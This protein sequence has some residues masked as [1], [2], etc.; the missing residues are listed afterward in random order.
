MQHSSN[1]KTGNPLLDVISSENLER[2]PPYL[3]PVALLL[4]EPVPA[5]ELVCVPVAGL[6]SVVAT[7]ADG[8]AV[9]IGMSDRERYSAFPQSS[10]R[11]CHHDGVGRLGPQ[12][13]VSHEQ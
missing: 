4:A 6:I 1:T 8:G 2:L 13:D 10:A 3:E 11:V 7:M 5:A 12:R 9:E